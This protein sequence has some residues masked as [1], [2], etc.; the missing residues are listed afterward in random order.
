MPDP[1]DL[2]LPLYGK[3]KTLTSFT[4]D[5]NT[6]LN[7]TTLGVSP[8]NTTITVKYRH[9]GGISHNISAKSIRTIKTLIAD[10]K[11]SVPQSSVFIN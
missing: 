11:K 2:S 4:I 1:S 9:G 10:F 7:T 3:R 6:L 5:P 8:Q